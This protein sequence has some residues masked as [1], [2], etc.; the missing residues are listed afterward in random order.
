[1]FRNFLFFMVLSVS[2][3]SIQSVESVARDRVLDLRGEQL[4]GDFTLR[5]SRGEFSLEQL[6]GKVVVLFFGYTKCPDVCP[7]SLA[8]LSQALN[9]LSEEELQQVQGV[10]ISVDPKRDTIQALDDYVSYFHPNLIGVTGSESEVAKVAKL[11]GAQYVEVKLE[12]SAFAYAVDHSATTYLISPQ[13]ELR[14]LLPHQTP[15]VM[16]LEAIRYLLAER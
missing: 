16:M 8:L 3:S 12:A 15:S 5:S 7:S 1:M 14:F 2:V 4:G 13:G 9:E 10:F 6:R 11:Y